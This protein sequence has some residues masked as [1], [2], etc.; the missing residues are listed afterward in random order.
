M[1][2]G[3]WCVFG[4]GGTT[5]VALCYLLA[6]RTPPPCAVIPG[7]EL[8]SAQ[9]APASGPITTEDARRLVPGMTLAQVERI[10]GPAR[11]EADSRC[12]LLYPPSE[13]VITRDG[14]LYADMHWA[15]GAVSVTVRVNNKTR[16]V[17]HVWVSLPE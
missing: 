16:C 9:S 8:V 10:L 13:L 4:L 6:S 12:L 3:H 15:S 7:P 17:K 2:R 11:V 5:L 1:A 14:S